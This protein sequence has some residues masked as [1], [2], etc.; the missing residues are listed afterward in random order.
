MLSMIGS[1]LSTPEPNAPQKFIVGNQYL[2]ERQLF[3]KT[4][5]YWTYIYAM[6]EE[7]RQTIDRKEFKHFDEMVKNLMEVKNLSRD[8]S[9]VALSHNGWNLT[10]TLGFI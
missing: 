10:E 5:K 9:L 3:D 1:L 6:D 4:A 7:N 2:N 8:Q